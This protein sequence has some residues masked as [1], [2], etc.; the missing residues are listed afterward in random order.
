MSQL[1]RLA[2]IPFARVVWALPI[3]FAIHEV[4]EWNILA[5]YQRYWTNTDGL[6]ARTVWTW[7]TFAGGVGL[8]ATWLL[9][10]FP[11]PR[12]TAHLLLLLFAFP[13]SHA[14][15]HLYYL[16]FFRA[17]NPGLLTAALLLLPAGHLVVRRAW[18][19]RLTA[20]WYLV[21]VGILCLVPI[22]GAARLHGRVPDGGLPWF[23]LGAAIAGWFFEAR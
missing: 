9:T 5:W 19:E 18:L 11:W 8:L 14:L 10:R 17:Y 22:V 2:G 16:G 23:N 15:I 4:E 7:L 13:I 3:A 20:P 21:S 6:A 12:L 1:T